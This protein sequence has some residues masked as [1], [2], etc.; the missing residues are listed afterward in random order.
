MVLIL[1]WLI[2]EPGICCFCLIDNRK[3][4]VADI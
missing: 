1:P 2:A 3:L 4:A